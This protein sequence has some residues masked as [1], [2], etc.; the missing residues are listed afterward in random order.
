[1]W[2]RDRSGIRVA[3]VAS[4]AAAALVL[5]SLVAGLSAALWQA[6][7]AARERDV[8]RAEAEQTEQVKNFI[9]DL[10]RASDPLDLS[11]AELTAKELLER[12]VERLRTRLGDQSDLKIE[13][14]AV[15]GQVSLSF[16]D[17]EG[18]RALFE[19]ALQLDVG[20]EP[21]DQLRLA[22]ALNG[23][24]RPHRRAPTLSGRRRSGTIPC[25][26]PTGGAPRP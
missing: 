5:V 13:L 22:A 12:G 15:I 23:L 9:V 21:R 19:E 20:P 8:A 11:G 14:L 25:R 18:A 26:R 7:V 16:G 10:F 1:M 6:G 24:A 2:K 17:H 3:P 4:A